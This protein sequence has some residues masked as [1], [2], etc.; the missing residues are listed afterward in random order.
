MEKVPAVGT[1]AKIPAVGL[2]TWKV[3]RPGGPEGRPE[4]RLQTPPG[5]SRP[6]VLSAGVWRSCG[7][8]LSFVLHGRGRTGGLPPLPPSET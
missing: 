5:P 2:G 8:P 7:I 4:S 6:A 1:I 3:R